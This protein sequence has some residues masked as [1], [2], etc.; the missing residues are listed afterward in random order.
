MSAHLQE[1]YGLNEPTQTSCSQTVNI[2]CEKPND[3]NVKID[4][5][6]FL[7][8][9][10]NVL[11]RSCCWPS[12]ESHAAVLE[13]HRYR[14]SST[15]HCQFL[16]MQ[17]VQLNS[18]HI[19]SKYSWTQHHSLCAFVI[20]ISQFCMTRDYNQWQHLCP[21]TAVYILFLSHFTIMVHVKY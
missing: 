8:L 5:R 21:T 13:E 15:W 3:R 19:V 6:Q 20:N 1:V 14:S 10:N 12:T 9:L 16:C 17:S 7:T 18:G 2:T 11:F 4:L